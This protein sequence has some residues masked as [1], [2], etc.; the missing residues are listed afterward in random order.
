MQLVAVNPTK[1]PA[2]KGIVDE[3]RKP[4]SAEAKRWMWIGAISAVAFMVAVAIA[5]V[6]IEKWW[7]DH[8]HGHD[9][10]QTPSPLLAVPWN[11]GCCSFSSLYTG[12]NWRDPRIQRSFVE[13]A[14]AAERQFFAAP[15]VSFDAVSG[16][17]YD[18]RNLEDTSLEPIEIR[19]ASA[20]SKES[21]Q[22]SL[23]ALS[24]QT[25]EEAGE[26]AALQPLVYSQ[27]EALDLLEK[28]VST[29]EDFD[30]RYPSF[31]GFLPW[32]CARGTF[33]NGACRGLD[34]P[35]G[36]LEAAKGWE[37]SMP[38]LDNGQMA[39]AT[40]A[41][42]RVLKQHALA[43]GAG[44]RLSRLAQR[45]EQRLQRMKASAVNLFYNGLGSGT[46][47]ALTWMTNL[48]V[49]AALGPENAYTESPYIL[50]DA[51]EGELMVLF[52]E[53]FGNWSGYPNEG[54]AERDLIWEHKKSRVGR[55]TFRMPD[56]EN[57]TVQRG[58][59][60]SSHE[61]WKILQMP[62]LAIPQVRKVFA[63]GELARLTYSFSESI[64]GLFAS[65]SAPGTLCAP[66]NYCSATGIESIAGEPV[67]ENF[68][69]TPYAA[70][71]SILVDRGAGLAW[72]NYMLSLPGMQSPYGS[73]E[74]SNA[75]EPG[76][77]TILTWDA[78][79]TTVL[80]M[81]GGTGDLIGRVMDEANATSKFVDRVGGMYD[82][83]FEDVNGSSALPLPPTA[84]PLAFQ[85]AWQGWSN[86]S[87][88]CNTSEF[89]P[90]QSGGDLAS[91][92]ISLE[93]NARRLR[94]L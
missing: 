5:V 50:D 78:K 58:F 67:T 47:R 6:N 86:T 64:P 72:Y 28:K 35:L 16:M 68:V 24:L 46:V 13:N 92:T 60:F 37:T 32:F 82:A 66:D 62:Y 2:I 71:P 83:V 30:R 21:I 74:S 27:E 89:L 18:G 17:T 70:F 80:A 22:L 7:H 81:L 19:A 52:M 38:G 48:S 11:A 88:G 57:L 91:S 94:G 36:P 59:W 1:V 39:W 63:N 76:V 79:A 42:V 54:Q 29:M 34:D 51:F 65:V 90:L 85:G 33:A 53:L 25:E 14:L 75:Q 20:P 49:D 26:L 73:L 69:V 41:L 23:L 9:E 10:T 84:L 4:K 55:A 40:A 44:D 93:G 56:G 43:D 77:K 12:V 8:G 31:G 61:Q 3:V 45:W 15:N 87:C